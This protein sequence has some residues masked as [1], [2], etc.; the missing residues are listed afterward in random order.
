MWFAALEAPA[1]D[2]WFTRFMLKLQEGSPQVLSLLA[3][4]PFPEKPPVYLRALQYRYFYTTKAQR[5]AT[6][7]I[8]QREYLRD[9]W[10]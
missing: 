9:Y 2:S 3:F 5:E 6:G 4:N 10:P 1:R 8:W 7:Q